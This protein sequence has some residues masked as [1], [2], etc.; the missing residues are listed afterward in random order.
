MLSSVGFLIFLFL[1][2]VAMSFCLK[3][4]DRLIAIEDR[5]IE[6]IKER[7]RRNDIQKINSK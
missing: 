5:V 1:F 6:K 3:N 4:E 2:A 7:C